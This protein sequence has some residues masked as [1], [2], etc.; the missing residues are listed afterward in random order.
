MVPKGR[1]AYGMGKADRR[2]PLE[3]NEESTDGRRRRISEASHG[4]N[5]IEQMF[6]HVAERLFLRD[7]NPKAIL[8]LSLSP[9]LLLRRKYYILSPSPCQPSAVDSLPQKR[10]QAANI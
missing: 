7:S 3:G 2:E 10:E 6:Y 1:N 4:R 8:S 5:T 9:G